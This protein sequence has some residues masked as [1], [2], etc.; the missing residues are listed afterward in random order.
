MRGPEGAS[1]QQCTGATRQASD[2]ITQI[3]QQQV[4]YLL[5]RSGPVRVG[6]DPEDVH[7]A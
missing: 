4:A 5:D 7:V 6:G 3:H 2:T 1:V